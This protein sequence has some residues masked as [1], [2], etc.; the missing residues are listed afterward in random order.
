MCPNLTSAGNSATHSHYGQTHE[1]SYIRTLKLATGPATGPAKGPAKARDDQTK[2]IEYNNRY[3]AV[4]G[5][6]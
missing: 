6:N 4:G 3:T 2:D 5:N 1:Q